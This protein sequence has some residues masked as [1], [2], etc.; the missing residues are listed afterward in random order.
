MFDIISKILVIFIKTG[1]LYIKSF[2]IY[3]NLGQLNFPHNYILILLAIN[4]ERPDIHTTLAGVIIFIT[5]I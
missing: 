5:H 2:L 1:N 3:S 4:N